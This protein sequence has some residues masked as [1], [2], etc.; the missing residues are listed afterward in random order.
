MRPG[1]GAPRPAGPAVE[2]SDGEEREFKRGLLRQQPH[3]PRH[4]I[5]RHGIGRDVLDEPRADTLHAGDEHHLV[6]LTFLFVAAAL[7][8]SV[9]LAGLIPARRAARVDPLIALRRE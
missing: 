8:A 6:G 5:G 9:A 3:Q 1:L 4:T 7:L 2:D